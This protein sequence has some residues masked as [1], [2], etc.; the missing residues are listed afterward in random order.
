MYSWREKDMTKL[1][2]G[3][4]LSQTEFFAERSWN[5]GR[6]IWEYLPSCAGTLT[7]ENKGTL[8]KHDRFL[9]AAAESTCALSMRIQM[10]GVSTDKSPCMALGCFLR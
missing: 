8:C 2:R 7:V 3:G 4:D 5:A 10:E 6:V 1:N 9:C